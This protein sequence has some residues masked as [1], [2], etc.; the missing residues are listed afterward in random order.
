MSCRRSACL[1]IYPCA[2][3]CTQVESACQLADSICR[4]GLGS[5]LSVQLLSI[6]TALDMSIDGDVKAKACSPSQRAESTMRYQP[7]HPMVAGE[8][9]VMLCM[10]RH[11]MLGESGLKL[12]LHVSG[13]SCVKELL[14]E[15]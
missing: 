1:S 5:R 4:T 6:R 10:R 7:R 8:F 9:A 11:T 2:V 3:V 12:A 15:G 14:Q 13:R